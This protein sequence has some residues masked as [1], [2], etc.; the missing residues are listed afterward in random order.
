M[1]GDVGALT[2]LFTDAL[3]DKDKQYLR[4]VAQRLL[5]HG[6]LLRER[7]AERALYDWCVEHA[8]W[9]DQWGEVLGMKIVWQREERV[10]V[11]LPEVPALVR[12]LRKDETLVALALWYDFDLEVREN[13]AHEVEFTVA[14]FNANFASK[15]P[16]LQG[17]SAS[18]LKEVLRLLARLNLIEVEWQPEFAESRIEILPTL[19]FAIPFPDLEEWL[20]HK[21]RFDDSSEAE[22]AVDEE[23]DLPKIEPAEAMPA[24]LG[25]SGVD[26]SAVEGLGGEELSVG[27]G[28]YR[29]SVS[30]A[31]DLEREAQ[32]DLF[33]GNEDEGETFEDSEGEPKD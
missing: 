2:P 5:A 26:A 18:R 3:K 28:E 33:G 8:D 17:L 25:G 12:K 21:Q 16:K 22:L 15:F 1:I 27:E 10:I 7:T 24:E 6:S 29:S 30:R 13:G 11:A 23:A 9:V 20:R 14:E 4:E 19:R 31:L 32:G